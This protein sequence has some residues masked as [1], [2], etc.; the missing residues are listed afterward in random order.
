MPS[1]LRDYY[2]GSRSPLTGG[3]GI[4][5]VTAILTA[6]PVLER[7]SPAPPLPYVV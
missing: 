4:G 2:C 1:I 7:V 3:S 6:Y 5:E